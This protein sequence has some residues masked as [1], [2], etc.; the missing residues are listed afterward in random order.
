MMLYFI[1]MLVCKCLYLML[2]LNDCMILIVL[3][4][5]YILDNLP[6]APGMSGKLE[7]HQNDQN[8][9]LNNY[10]TNTTLNYE[11]TEEDAGRFWDVE[12]AEEI[13]QPIN[14]TEPNSLDEI[15]HIKVI[16]IN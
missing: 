15:V 9:T 2:T 14:I 7:I 8:T 10:V 4:Y 16:I 13:D 11:W 1:L 6:V 5:F 12:V 3:L